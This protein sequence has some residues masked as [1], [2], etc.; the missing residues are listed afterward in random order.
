MRDFAR[1]IVIAVALLMALATPTLASGVN[2][3]SATVSLP[4]GRNLRVE[5]D[6]GSQSVSSIAGGYRLE[7]GGLTIVFADGRLTVD[8]EEREVPDF[9]KTL[10]ITVTGGTVSVSGD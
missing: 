8:G 9:A 3:S 1:V 2:M 4:D 6:G 5:S 10:T 7:V